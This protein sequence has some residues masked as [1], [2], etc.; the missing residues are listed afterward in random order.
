[1]HPEDQLAVKRDA[2]A[3]RVRPHPLA[4]PAAWPALLDEAEAEFETLVTR[5]QRALVS[6]PARRR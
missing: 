5:E 6:G 3:R 4:D 2:L 1:M